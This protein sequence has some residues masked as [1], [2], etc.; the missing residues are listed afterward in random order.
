MAK[1]RHATLTANKNTTP[2]WR[3]FHSR[4]FS[5]LLKLTKIEAAILAFAVC[6]VALGLG[7]SLQSDAPTPLIEEVRESSNAAD[8]KSPIN[9]DRTT[10]A[11]TLPDQAG[12]QLKSVSRSTPEQAAVYTQAKFTS[13]SNKGHLNTAALNAAPA[14]TAESNITQAIA[15]DATSIKERTANPTK[16][17]QQTLKKGDN[18]SMVFDRVGLNARDVYQVVESGSE[19]K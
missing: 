7:N 14:N 8:V 5:L 12:R 1:N 13:S 10:F 17:I 16:R 2:W 9:N 6:S 4:V 18:L 19:G 3:N 15:S 11:L